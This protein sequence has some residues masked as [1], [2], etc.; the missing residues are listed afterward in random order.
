MTNETQTVG[1]TID[2][3]MK[4]TFT[5]G[6][7]SGYEKGLNE[8]YRLAMD[9]FK[10]RQSEVLGSGDSVEEQIEVSEPMIDPATLAESMS[11]A[12]K[13]I[14][15]APHKKH[16]WDNWEESFIDEIDSGRTT[17]NELY[18][19]GS[20]FGLTP[21]AIYSKANKLGY[22]IVGEYFVKAGGE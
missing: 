18:V 7:S 17:V 22:R 9:A 12:V 11:E 20:S 3:I 1:S 14:T 21:A 16:K 19:A 15:R 2:V 5:D 6:F 8:G 13:S 10:S 4:K